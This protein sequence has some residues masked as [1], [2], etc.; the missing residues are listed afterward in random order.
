MGTCINKSLDTV[1]RRGIET[2]IPKIVNVYNNQMGVV[3]RGD[4]MLFSYEV[5][6]NRIK[7]WYMK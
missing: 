5:E 3:D 4:Q 2:V 7:K 6:Q 1:K